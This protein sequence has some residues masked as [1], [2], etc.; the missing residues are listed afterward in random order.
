METKIRMR[1]PVKKYQ[2]LLATFKPK[3]RNMKL[4]VVVVVIVI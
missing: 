4:F 1:L 3:K 2:R